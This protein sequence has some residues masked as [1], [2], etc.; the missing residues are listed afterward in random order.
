MDESI[1]VIVTEH[2][3]NMKKEEEMLVDFPSLPRS[4]SLHSFEQ[5]KQ[6]KQDVKCCQIIR[7][8]STNYFPDYDSD[9]T[10]DENEYP[11]TQRT[12]KTAAKYHKSTRRQQRRSSTG[13]IDLE[14]PLVP[15]ASTGVRF[16]LALNTSHS[17]R[18]IDRREG[19]GLGS[20]HQST[21][22]SRPQTSCKDQQPACTAMQNPKRGSWAEIDG[23]NNEQAKILDIACRGLSSSNHSSCWFH[24]FDDGSVSSDENT[25]CF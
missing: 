11:S 19:M 24:E 3:N 12:L 7:V 15:P 5:Y 20:D 18:Q 13:T 10:D 22:P 1:K 25:F 14:S 23:T 8:D 6:K 4:K 21:G 2:G 17:R 16:D 9:I